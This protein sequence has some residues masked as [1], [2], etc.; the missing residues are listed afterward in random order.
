MFGFA[1]VT[2]QDLLLAAPRLEVQ[3]A[4]AGIQAVIWYVLIYRILPPYISSFIRSMRTR[5]RFLDNCARA[6]KKMLMLDFQG[7]RELLFEFAVIFQ[8]IM[9][10]HLVGGLLCLPA[11]LGCSWVPRSVASALACHGALCEV[12][13]EIQDTLVRLK[14]RVCDGESG[15][16]K[17]PASFMAAL[18]LHHAFSQCLV[19]PLNMYYRDNSYYHEAV[20]L[21]QAASMA[22][23]VCQSYGFT[24]DVSKPAEMRQMQVAVSAAFLVVVWSRLLRYAYIWY[25]LIVNFLADENVFVLRLAMPP[26]I[27]GSLFNILVLADFFKKFAKFV[28]FPRSAGEDTQDWCEGYSGQKSVDQGIPAAHAAPPMA[29]AFEAVSGKKEI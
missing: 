20:L 13:W 16:K 3:L 28:L 23:M 15:R 17:N 24:L 12:G 19:L 5:E 14:E 10:Q 29:Q 4:L 18:L 9:L 26:L 22:A 2:I 21:L 11:V 7:D 25:V 1:S 6:Y 27:M 8:G